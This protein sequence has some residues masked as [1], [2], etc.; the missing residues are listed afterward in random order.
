M[1]DPHEQIGLRRNQF[2]WNI[3]LDENLTPE[4]IAI[5]ELPE[6]GYVWSNPMIKLHTHCYK[7][8]YLC[9][10]YQIKTYEC[11]EEY[12][13]VTDKMELTLEP[14]GCTNLRITYFP[15]AKLK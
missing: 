14:Y 5:E 8:P 3:A 12:P 13:Y 10:P 1:K 15:K 9:A 2:T 4:D 6:S 11:F 7:A